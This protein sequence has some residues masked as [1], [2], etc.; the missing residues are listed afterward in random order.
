MRWSS[1]RV[2]SIL[3]RIV[4]IFAFGA[5]LAASIKH[6]A[7]YYHD[8]EPSNTDWVGS[9]ALAISI[10]GTALI[11]NIG[12][13]FFGRNM[14]PWAKTFIWFFIFGLTAF[15]W[16]INWEYA[17]TYQGPILASHLDPIW[18]DINPVL[19]SS[20]AFL[21]LAYA[22]VAEVFS[23]KTK[24]LDELRA[25]LAELTGE[26]AT[27]A[28]Q[29]KAVKGPGLIASLRDK[30]IELKQA[31]N[32]VLTT[33]N[34]P[35]QKEAEQRKNEES[36]TPAKTKVDATPTEEKN[37]DPFTAIA[38]A[39]DVP[40]VSSQG[41]RSLT[42]K[43]TAAR[44]HLSESYIRDLKKKGKLRSP[45]R[46]KSKVTIKSID[47][48]E[49]EHQKPIEREGP[50]EADS[51]APFTVVSGSNTGVDKLKKTLDVLRANPHI[52]DEDLAP[53]LDLKRPA[54]ARFWRLK[55]MELHA[56]SEQQNGHHPETEIAV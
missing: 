54:S 28:A 35:V 3:V 19:A 16:L 33:E 31:V 53:F 49:L 13:M 52:S 2:F 8:F 12:L 44:L 37:T 23:V 43:E 21:N 39:I 40:E 36:K 11:L 32:E 9:Y 20:F 30:T 17:V 1:E 26:K 5:F 7:T 41:L 50:I 22:L 14:S 25:E 15:S 42:V 4:L 45:T 51:E 6:V 48:Y 24:T 10:D 56:A 55:A 18:R 27:V 47:A 46:N 29:I 34:P 38:P